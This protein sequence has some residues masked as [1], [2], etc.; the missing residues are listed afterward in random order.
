MNAVRSSSD[1]AIAA[2]GRSAGEAADFLRTL[3]HPGR[4]RIVC[5][6][7]G[8]DLAAGGLARQARLA[9][10]ALSQQASVL[11][12]AGL[13]ERRR[14]GRTVHYRLASA[15]ARAVAVLLAKRLGSAG[16]KRTSP[17]ATRTRK[18]R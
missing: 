1:V 13:I 5:A 3:A 4:L 2:L 18:T 6:L 7:I 16:S 11:E 14:E 10:P 9:A 8:G 17:G 12:S 15:D